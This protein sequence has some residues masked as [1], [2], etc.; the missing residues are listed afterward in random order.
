METGS[1]LV[2]CG[3]W[4]VG[5]SQRV[6]ALARSIQTNYHAL[7][8]APTT[9]FDGLAAAFP[10]GKVGRDPRLSAP[11]GRAAAARVCEQWVGG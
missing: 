4:P 6:G 10:K 2:A 1:W 7:R 11:Q 3:L 8:T 9:P 5:D